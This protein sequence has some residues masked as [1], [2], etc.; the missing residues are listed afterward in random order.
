M[1]LQED[2]GA[3]SRATAPISHQPATHSRGDWRAAKGT[4]EKSRGGFLACLCCSYSTRTTWQRLK[5][6][7]DLDRRRLSSNF[8]SFNLSPLPIEDEYRADSGKS[9]GGAERREEREEDLTHGHLC[10][11]EERRSRFCKTSSVCLSSTLTVTPFF[12][13]H[14][15]PSPILHSLTIRRHTH[16]HT[17]QR[18]L[19]PIFSFLSFS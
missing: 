12:F 7:I 15:C 3:G 18:T 17:A 16:T 19:L 11:A 13:F 6:K 9:S 14:S 1:W 2:L 4:R 10:A 5:L 8:P